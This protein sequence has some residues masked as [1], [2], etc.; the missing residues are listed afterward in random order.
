[1]P[2]RNPPPPAVLAEID[3]ARKLADEV[4]DTNVRA[5][6]IGSAEVSAEQ[7][8]A[9]FAALLAATYEAPALVALLV[10]ALQRLAGAV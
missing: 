1:M 5:F 9:D 8:S 4:L 2:Y 7:A 10:G 3:Q 6:R